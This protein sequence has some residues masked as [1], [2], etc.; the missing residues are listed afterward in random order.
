MP[1]ETLLDLEKFLSASAAYIYWLDRNNIYRGCNKI[2]AE[3]AGL[4]SHLDIVGQRN[5]DLPWNKIHPE[6][7]TAMDKINLEVMSTN[8][9]KTVEE[10][11]IL[12]GKEV[13]LLSQKTPLRN[14]KEEIIGVLSISID[15]TD[16]KKAEQVQ[17]GKKEEM[18]K[19]IETLSGCIAHEIRTPLSI[20]GLNIDRLKMEFD[21]SFANH[22]NLEQKNEIRHF[23]DNIKFA[24][25]SGS[26][27]IEMFIIKLRSLLNKQTRNNRTERTSIKSCINTVI[28]EYPFYSNESELIVWD[29]EANEDFDYIGDD[30]LTRHVL[31]NLIQN[32]LRSIK[33]DNKGKI[34]INLKHG[35]N[36]N[37][38]IFKDT[39]L[40]ISAE[41]AKTIFDKTKKNNN[42]ER[43]GMGLS[44]CKMI[45]QSYNGNI[46]FDSKE[47]EYVEFT[48]SFPV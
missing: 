40:G 31:F 14:S 5:S 25:K 19:L 45:M 6:I 7:A 1:E 2:F 23:I 48:L 47:G 3:A 20:I 39:A 22:I 33:E 38:L 32:A 34:Y 30:L 29:N 27:I 42:K 28:K 35:E 12:N 18:S 10:Q 46:T 43:A 41:T 24:I 36:F 15:I 13:I 9:A 17:K 37:Y 21:S 11:T 16:N 4:A 26:N 44:F 8:T